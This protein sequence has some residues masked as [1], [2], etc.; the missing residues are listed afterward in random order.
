MKVI[1]GVCFESFS[2]DIESSDARWFYLRFVDSKTYR[3]F[4]P[5]VFTGRAITEYRIDDLAP[6]DS[7]KF[8]AVDGLGRNASVLVD[9]DTMTTYV[10][11]GSEF[12]V[13]VDMGEKKCIKALGNY[14][15]L[16]DVM[17]LRAKGLKSDYAEASLPVDYRIST[18]LDGEN[19]TTAREGLF[20]A[21]AG[22]EIV[23]FNPTDARYVRLDVLS[24]TG[25]RS[26]RA[27]FVNAPAK[28]ALITLFE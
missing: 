9:G 23:R 25:K 4:S 10:A 2:F 1:E 26:G 19:F 28:M 12:T 27:A 5:P 17:E 6:I 11:D 18:S 7:S 21:F 14:A 22:E 13:T 16:V 24:T 3:T 20:R 8:K 15:A